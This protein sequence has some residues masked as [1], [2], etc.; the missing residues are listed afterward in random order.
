LPHKYGMESFAHRLLLTTLALEDALGRDSRHEID[1]LV[2]QRQK[3]LDKL[4]KLSLDDAAVAVLQTVAAVEKRMMAKL[5]E[6]RAA[7]AD[8][9]RDRQ[10]VKRAMKAYGASAGPTTWRQAS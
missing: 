3:L 1:C 7:V 8:Q 4:E 5:Q 6:A 2:A 10:Q 9:L